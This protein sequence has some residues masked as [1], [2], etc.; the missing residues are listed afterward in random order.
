M[1]EKSAKIVPRK[2]SLLSLAN[3]VAKDKIVFQVGL[4][5]AKDHFTRGGA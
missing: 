2:G 3:L 1:H 5:E 4:K